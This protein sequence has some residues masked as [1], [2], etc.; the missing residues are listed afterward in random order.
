M[1]NRGSGSGLIGRNSSKTEI[2]AGIRIKY[3][4]TDIEIE[5]RKGPNDIIIDSRNI[6]IDYLSSV[7]FTELYNRAR[8]N[9]V[10]VQEFKQRELD[11]RDRR[12][13]EERENRPD[14]ELGGGVPWGNTAYR[15]QARRDRTSTRAQRR[16]NR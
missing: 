10:I 5:Y 13:A 11:E 4:G 14:Y 1:G 16:K 6:P 3:Q 15:R 12:E 8:D 2:L 7:S 9:G